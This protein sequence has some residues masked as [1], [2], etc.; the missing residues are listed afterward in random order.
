M[1]KLTIEMV[2]HQEM[3]STKLKLEYLRKMCDE[4]KFNHLQVIKNSVETLIAG[5][6]IIAQVMAQSI[7]EASD[8][9]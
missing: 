6:T 4:T 7:I 3:M 1:K 2:V 5:S 9:N 8:D